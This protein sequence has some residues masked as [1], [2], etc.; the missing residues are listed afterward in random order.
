MKL[1][2]SLITL[3]L[4][5]GSAYA[6]SGFATYYTTKSCQREGTS[7]VFT[8]NGER[9]NESAMTCALRSRRFGRFYSVYSPTTDKTVFVRHNDYGPGKGPLKRGVIIDL[10]PKAFKEVCGDLSIGKCEVN[11][12]EVQ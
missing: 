2:L 10:T 7:G 4:V 1:L 9:Y 8:A 6:E 3:M 5:T 12:Q 11:V